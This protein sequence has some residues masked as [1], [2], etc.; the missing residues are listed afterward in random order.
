MYMT[1]WWTCPC[2]LERLPCV[3]VLSS[4]F[5]SPLTAALCIRA[6][7]SWREGA[8]GTR[9]GLLTA[10]H[11]FPEEIP[12][13]LGNWQMMFYWI[14]L[15]K[16]SV[17]QSENLLHA[18]PAACCCCCCSKRASVDSA[19]KVRPLRAVPGSQDVSLLPCLLFFCVSLPF[20][21][22]TGFLWVALVVL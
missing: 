10:I 14:G 6:E 1:V 5:P 3:S 22:P 2:W 12:K 8:L 15:L 13:K 18:L 4:P 7:Q 11:T 9:L 21:L 17:G 20:F 16:L 19:R